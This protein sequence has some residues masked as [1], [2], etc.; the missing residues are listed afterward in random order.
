MALTSTIRYIRAL[1][2]SA[3]DGSGKTGLAF[4]DFTAKYNFNNGTLAS[5]TPETITTLGTYQA[6]SDASHIRIKELNSAD[7]TKGVYEVHFHDTQ[8]ASGKRIWLYLS[9]AGA[10]IQPLEMELIVQTQVQTGDSYAKLTDTTFGLSALRYEMLSR[11]PHK[12]W[13]VAASGGDDANVGT[14][15]LPLATYAQAITNYRFGDWIVVLSGAHS[16]PWAH[17]VSGATVIFETGHTLRSSSVNSTNPTLTVTG[18]YNKFFYYDIANTG[19]GTGIRSPNT[20][21][22]E[23]GWGSSSGPFDGHYSKTCVDTWLH[24]GNVS[25]GFDACQWSGSTNFLIEWSRLTTDGTYGTTSPSRCL[26]ADENVGNRTT[27]VIRHCKIAASRTDVSAQP[28]VGIEAGCNTGEVCSPLLIEH[29]DISATITNAGASGP[30][31]CLLRSSINIDDILSAKVSWSSFSA[32]NTGSGTA[33][34]IDANTTGSKVEIG[35]S[36]YSLAACLGP[37]NIVDDGTNIS[38]AAASASS[39]DGKAGQIKLKTD[40]LPSDPADASD[41]ATAFA[42]VPGAVRTN[43]T[44]ELGRIDVATSTRLP[45]SSYTTP[46]TAAANASAVRTNLTTELGVINTNLDAK[47][48]EAGGGSAASDFDDE[49]VP[50]ARKWI[51][52]SKASGLV[53]D[54][55]IRLAHSTTAKF[56][57]D[58]KNA[59]SVNVRVRTVDDVLIYSGTALGIT[60][61]TEGRED[62]E[63]K[64]NITGVT[65]GQYVIEVDV[66]D[67]G[68][69]THTGR[70]RLE[71]VS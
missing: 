70:V 27:G 6:P 48:S 29:C 17:S 1:D 11:I 68:T 43:L 38:A 22:N 9:A 41:I 46:P 34:H 71:V 54:R 2:S 13:F 18:N 39:A 65:V 64:F 25:S 30:A 44:T 8:L 16:G 24:H 5:L 61:G 52:V 33:K 36:I 51:L 57:V 49:P 60:F 37:S 28:A 35:N 3:T 20:T 69:D 50:P 55:T 59:L 14:R 58:F 31:T 45:T 66:T 7:P 40:N 26:I 47:V 42:A 32:A 4:G 21:G 23:F 10:A 15:D 53:G 67:T 63:S 12:T 62:S 56:A 19:T